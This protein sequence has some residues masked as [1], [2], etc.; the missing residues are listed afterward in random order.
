MA[1]LG[2]LFNKNKIHPAVKS[3]Y[4][5]INVDFKDRLF[6]GDLSK[7]NK[8]LLRITKDAFTD[9]NDANINTCFQIY[10]QTFIRSHGGFSQEFFM[11][12]YI[13]ERLCER[14]SFVTKQIVINCVN[15]SLEYIYQ[16]EPE[17]LKR[18]QQYEAIQK[19]ALKIAFKRPPL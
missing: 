3:I 10:L 4:Q 7:A 18:V 6:Y 12:Q 11:P 19:Y 8:V 16:N 9:V 14:F 17:Q 1:L 5:T 13:T 2:N 15:L